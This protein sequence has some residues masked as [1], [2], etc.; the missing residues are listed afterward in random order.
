MRGI[1]YRETPGLPPGRGFRA[2]FMESAPP[3]GL[4]GSAVKGR[5]LLLERIGSGGEGQ[6]Y[7]ATDREDGRMVAVK[8][9]SK[10]SGPP[11]SESGLLDLAD[12]FRLMR[13]LRAFAAVDHPNVV[14]LL[15][16]GVHK[17][18]P[19]LVME[20]LSGSDLRKEIVSAGPMGW[21]AAKPLILQ[22]CDAIGALH[23]K[24]I[25]H[26]DIKPSNLFL[27]DGPGG[28]ILKLIDLDLVKFVGPAAGRDADDSDE[29]VG[30]PAYM[31]PEM[32]DGM[33]GCDTRLDIYSLGATIYEMLAGV[34]PYSPRNYLE[35]MMLQR[36]RMPRLISDVRPDAVLPPGVQD[37]VSKALE[38]DPEKRYQSVAELKAD[39]EAVGNATIPPAPR[40]LLGRAWR[41][42]KDVADLLRGRFDPLGG[43]VIQPWDVDPLGRSGR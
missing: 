3:D 24:G 27:A 4:I 30:T 29:V 10:L 2:H 32:L 22:M 19:F 41:F 11:Q 34:P 40:S 16:S 26:R 33:A 31:A 28:R 42:I 7:L 1:A 6:V 12:H 5:Y 39:V 38:H 20:R 35:L 14:K 43:L 23:E 17:G 15:D 25:I 13:E 18:V 36:Q 21:D 9:I 37:I 8:M